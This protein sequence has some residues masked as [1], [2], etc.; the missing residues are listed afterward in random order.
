L[1][2]LDIVAYGRE[3]DGP[4]APT[5]GVY[6]PIGSES[7]PIMQFFDSMGWHKVAEQALAYFTEKQHE[8]GFIQ[9]FGG[10]MLETGAAL[11][12]MGEH[13]RYTGDEAWVKRIKNNLV[14]ACEYMLAWRR[15]NIR[16]ELR[17]RGYGLLE[18]K[19]ADPP[20]PFHSF[21]LNGYAY[22]GMARAA[23]MLA[24]V[25]LKE[26]RRWAREAAA[27]KQDI[28]TAFFEARA[29][30]P[31]VPLGDGTWAPSAPPW[32]ESSGPVALYAEPAHWFTHGTFT[33]R[34]SLLGP[35]Y[36]ILQ[37]VIDPHEQAADFLVDWHAELMC[38]RNVALSQ[39][40]Y[41]R[42]DYAHI[43]RGEVKPFLKT[44][45]NAFTGLADRETY[46]FW[47]H[48]FHA[49]PHKTHEEGWFLM[50]TR[51]MLWLEDGRTLRLLPGVPR[52]WL[53]HGKQIALRNVASY[54]GPISLQ[55]ESKV[56]DCVIEATIECRSDRQPQR[57]AVRLPHPCG[58]KAVAAHGGA[59][60]PESETVLIEEFRDS[61]KV[62]LRF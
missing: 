50:Q 33:A 18:G 24:K 42:H 19:V 3:P 34:D 51:W 21:M 14:R 54:F 40:Y 36:L 22:L 7:S 62:V 57:V 61:A 1:L 47:E 52:A 59:Y 38:V 25:D 32:A 2:H 28:R 58:L 6:C 31:V 45:Y 43:R 53:E 56:N 23:E 10:Y 37:E 13:Y 46:T 48:Y 15:R 4:I 16:E 9:N 11:W 49:S 20:D 12:S 55:V 35:I 27:L 60:C 44:Y 26:S 17:G 30:S 29:R 41:S 5:I 39:P 8:D